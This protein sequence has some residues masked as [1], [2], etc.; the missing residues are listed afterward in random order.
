MKVAL[1]HDFLTQLGGAERVLQE[2]H[3]L[4]PDAPVY[5]VLYNR[6]ATDGTFDGWDIRTSFLQKLPKFW[7]Y[8][9]YLPMLPAA[10]KSLNLAGYD[11]IISDASALIK[12]VVV[13]AGAKHICYCH[14]PT[15]YLWQERS[16]YVRNLP[17][18]WFVKICAQPVLSFLKRWDWKA[19]QKIDF[20]IANSRE[21]Q[22]R[23]EKY[24]QRD[25]EVVY[26]PVDT[27]F[28][29][30]PGQATPK[31]YFFTASRL[32]PYKKI[33]LV[34]SV[35]SRL[36]LPLK[37]AGTGT[38]SQ[39][40]RRSAGRSVEFLGRV[41]DEELRE[42]YRGARAFIFPALEDA[43]IMMLEAAACGTPVIAFRAGGAME[44]V[45]E[46]KT[47]D[48]FDSQTEASLTEAIKKFETERFRAEDLVAKAKQYDKGE[49]RQKILKVASR[50]E[51][52]N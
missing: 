44:F 18:P 42:L 26:P 37:V 48:F 47:G 46:G 52:R 4:F 39:K 40:L 50:Y 17:Y 29:S 2:L 31:N 27:A 7:S 32:E 51:N 43:G 16:D 28:F 24:Y 8:K 20:F 19:A 45:E 33:D 9:W 41:G 11:L 13:P 38:L 14:T 30:P 36:N 3:A 6:Q 49:F 22:R 25:S 12:G 10:V 34:V 21:V 5:T 15:R 35:F 1:V 23:I